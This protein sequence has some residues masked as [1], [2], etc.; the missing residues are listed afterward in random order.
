MEARAPGARVLIRDEEWLVR[1]ANL[2]DL[3][4]YG[5][6]CLGVSETVRRR[7]ALFL[8]EIDEVRVLDPLETSL[9]TSDH[10]P[11]QL[12]VLLKAGTGHRIA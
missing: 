1:N 3:G 5:L 9:V 7:D 6:E 10:S 4:G 8:A 12:A 11:S 2:C